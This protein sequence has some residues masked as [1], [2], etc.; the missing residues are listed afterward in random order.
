MKTRIIALIV[1]AVLAIGGGLV[2]VNY[3]RTAD[4]RAF[5]GAELTDV[6]MVASVVPAGT[7]TSSLESAIVVKSVPTAFV[8]DGAVTSLDALTGLIAAVELQP[9]EQVLASRFVTADEFGENS[10]SIPVPAGLQEISI[11]VDAQRVIGG[12]IAPGDEVG[13]FTSLEETKDDPATTSLMLSSVLVTSVATAAGVED[14]GST[15]G[16]VLVSLAVSADD[17]QKLVFSAEFGRLW[18]S[19]QDD[20]SKPA[21]AGAVER[22]GISG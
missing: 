18:L 10:G 9:G 5:N 14:S 12:R 13:I 15:G 21:K 8:V 3:V 6:L 22:D 2:L 20:A 16:I 19:K 7:P 11:A 1:A 17:A 4:A